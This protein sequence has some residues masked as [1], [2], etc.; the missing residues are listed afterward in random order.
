[1]RRSEVCA[2]QTEDIEGD[3]VHI[4]KA[5]VLDEN[6]KWVVKTT[7]TT[8]STRDIIIPME[9]VDKIKKQGYVY[10]GHPNSIADH[11]EKT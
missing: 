4:H 6:K 3:I 1:M 5:L 7:K 8:E 2:L 11:L 10:K 9:L